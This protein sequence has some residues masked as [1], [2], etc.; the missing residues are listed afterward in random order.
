[1]TDDKYLNLPPRFERRVRAFSIDLATSVLPCLIFLAFGA[2]WVLIA[3]IVSLSL[4]FILPLFISKGQTF[5]CRVEKI[6]YVNLDNSD[7][8]LFKMIVREVCLIVFCIITVGIYSIILY[9]SLSEKV[10]SK[11]LHDKIFKTKMISLTKPNENK[12]IDVFDKTNSM[13]GKF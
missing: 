2:F 11:S 13:K 1:M 4:V 3:T 8:N 12:N 9:F 10:I 6:K 5:G 7:V